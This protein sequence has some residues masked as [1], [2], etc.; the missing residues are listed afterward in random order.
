LDK[1]DADPS[2]ILALTFTDSAAKNM[3]DR[4]AQLIG[5]TAYYVNISTFHSFCADVIRRYPEYFPIARNSEPLTAL[6]RFEIIEQLIQKTK[7][8][9][10]KPLNM[11]LYYLKEILSSISD[12]KREGINPDQFEK[13]IDQDAAQI[14]QNQDDYKKAQLA[15][16][17]KNIGKQ[18]ELLQLYRLYQQELRTRQRYDFD[19]MIMLVV[20]A[21]QEHELLLRLHQEQLHYFLV[22]EYQDTNSAQN[23]VVDLLASYWGDK[24]NICV[25]GDPHQAIFR[26]QGASIE[27]MLGFV[28]RYQEATVINLAQG[29]RCTQKIYDSAH[30]LIGN[31]KLSQVDSQADSAKNKLL[32]LLNQPLK[33]AVDELRPTA[34]IP[35]NPIKVY[36]APTQT[37]ESIF[38]AKQIK[39]LLDS[40]TEPDEIAVLYRYNSDSIEIAEAL[41]KWGV[42]YEIEGG[43]DI[44]QREFTNQLLN[45]FQILL[46]LRNTQEDQLVYQVLHY[47][48]F[49]LD[50]LKVMKLGRVAGKLKLSLLEVIDRGYSSIK[51]AELQAVLSED[52]FAEIKKFTDQLYHWSSLDHQLLF[53][54][55]FERVLKEAEIFEWLQAQPN[56]AQLLSELNSLYRQVKSMVAS[57]R[58]FKLINF[59]QAIEVMREHKLQ[60]TVEDL[61]IKKGAVS[62]AT[63]H[64]AK[65]QEW[66][67][68]FI[69]QC[70]DGKW[71]NR[72][73]RNI[74]PLPEGILEHTQIS[75][76][77][78]NEDERRA[79][80]VAL[81]RAKDSVTV[82][83]PETIV[84][85]N[86]TDEKSASQFLYQLGDQI[87]I[88]EDEQLLNQAD[89]LLQKMIE[90]PVTVQ[91]SLDQR[92]FFEL[93]LKDFKLSVTALNT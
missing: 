55:W 74:L 89:E 4:L 25:V 11:P 35:D 50:S 16:M 53:T 18:R 87:Q 64:K 63:V 20:E 75:D 9:S 19:D 77:E 29:Y 6:E 38:V 24:A 82:C 69:I 14:E 39:E 47:P 36:S 21:F 27:N 71:G 52:E 84:N 41:T 17:K 78:L 66:R 76:K 79:F 15:Q 88:A 59:L 81:T 46:D 91:P 92:Q 45:F 62:L 12:L 73:P 67:H 86:H 57:D 40:G 60:I 3:R 23:K 10:I 33:S 2:T 48:W 56:Y 7:L 44:L 51:K 70:V 5:P 54:H 61:N 93:I 1:T 13:I 80:Y 85:D 37:M 8:S 58:Q 90:P 31:N 32:K 72:R 65:G 83:Y 22:D 26:F 43:D 49:K 30:T 68:V 42:R 28:D 34:D